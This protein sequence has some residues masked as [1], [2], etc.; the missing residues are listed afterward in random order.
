MVALL[1]AIGSL[2]VA[3]SER[4]KKVAE[5]EASE[6]QA[7]AALDAALL[8]MVEPLKNRLV[9]VQRE[10]DVSRSESNLRMDTIRSQLVA[11]NAR[12]S[13]L[14]CRVD[15]LEKERATL[16]AGIVVLSKQLDAA[17]VLPAFRLPDAGPAGS[18][19]GGGL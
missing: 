4:K 13:E 6:G 3:M 7:R 16:V 15:A 14:S 1:T 9:E 11:A 19:Q 17:G 12:I 8:G 2:L 18:V 5:A 10:L